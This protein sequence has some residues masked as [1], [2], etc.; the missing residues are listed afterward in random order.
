MFEMPALSC[1]GTP[2]VRH[3]LER[4]RDGERRCSTLDKTSSFGPKACA[5]PWFI[6][7][8]QIDSGNCARAMRDDHD[9]AVALPHAEDRARQGFVALGIEIRI[10]LVE[11]DQERIAIERA[12]KRDALRLAGRQR[13]ALL[14]DLRLVAL[15]R[16][17]IRSWTPAALAAAIDGFGVGARARSG[18]YSAP[19]CRPAARRPAADSRYAGRALPATIGRARRRRG[20]LCRAPAA[21]RRPA[22][23]AS[24]DLPEPLGP[25]MP[26]PLPASSS[27]VTSLHDD[28]LDR[29]AAPALTLSTV[30]VV[31]GGCSGIGARCRGQDR[32]QLVQPV[33]ALPRGDE[34]LPVGD[35]EIDRRQRARAQDRARNDDAGG[36]LL[37]DHQVGADGEHGRTAASCAALWRPRRGRRRRRSPLLAAHDIAGWPRDQRAA[38]RPA[39]PMAMSASALR[40]LLPRAVARDC[41]RSVAALVGARISISVNKVSDNQDDGAG[42]A[43]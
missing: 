16:L 12:G 7:K 4:P 3:D 9:D 18:R 36:G 43:R 11:H 41:A 13:S 10:G 14:A 17:T 40:R 38:M 15:G 19:R 20:A 30:S 27:N 1:A 5:L 22:A 28:L 35:R 29:R 33:P 32:Q 2:A 24:D 31:T 39:M 37:V 34:A 6:T 26:R 8:R 23:R 42:R 21:R 25:M